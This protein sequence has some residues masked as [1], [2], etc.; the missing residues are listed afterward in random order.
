MDSLIPFLGG[1]TKAMSPENESL[2]SF[3]VLGISFISS[4]LA[5]AKTR[6]P[7]DEYLSI[8]FWISSN[9]SFFY[10]HKGKTFS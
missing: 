1:S 3:S 8:C 6:Y 10:L 4:F 2:F 5:I 7:K 9:S